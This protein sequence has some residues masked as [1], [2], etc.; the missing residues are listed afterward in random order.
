MTHTHVNEEYSLTY[1]DKALVRDSGGNTLNEVAHPRIDD[2]VCLNVE[3]LQ[4][5]IS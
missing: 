1:T 5:G 2:K 4:V 3:L